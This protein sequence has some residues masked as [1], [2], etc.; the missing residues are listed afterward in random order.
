[1]RISRQFVVGQSKNFSDYSV[2]AMPK[3]Y[4]LGSFSVASWLYPGSRDTR[5][6]ALFHRSTLH[7]YLETHRSTL[8]KRGTVLSFNISWHSR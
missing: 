6:V 2:H 3:P 4:A 1:M 8:L 5:L 7:Y